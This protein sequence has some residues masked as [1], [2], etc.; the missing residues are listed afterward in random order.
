MATTPKKTHASSQTEKDLRQNERSSLS[1]IEDSSEVIA[2]LNAEDIITYMS[3]SITSVLGYTP[4]E[5]EGCNAGVLV[6]P[7]DLE[8]MQWVLGEIG[9]SPGKSLRAEYRL[10][11]KDGSWRWFEGSETNLLQVPGIG[12]IVGTFRDITK[13]KLAPR[14]HWG[15]MSASEHFAQFCE[16]DAFLIHSV[17]AFIGAGLRA[18]D[19][20]IV[21]A[22]K[23]HRGGT[24]RASVG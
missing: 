14:S 23:P 5:I 11:C 7:D 2:L 4:E 9:R 3:P 12:A 20:C 19:A 13:R 1:L 8:T 17:S 6:H 15:E 18:G 10:R 16:T 22:T 21:L 24:G